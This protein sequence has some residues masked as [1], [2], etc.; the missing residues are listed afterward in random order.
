[1]FEK[2]KQKLKR[3][4][5]RV[6]QKVA[7]EAPPEVPP[8]V[9]PEAPPEAPPKAPPEVPLPG[10]PRKA[11]RR[12]VKRITRRELAPEDVEDI[13]WELQVGLLESDVAVPVAD[14]VI[15]RVKSG[16]KGRKLGMR[17]DPKK[18]AD[19]VLRQAIQEVLTT[20]QRVDLLKV[21]DAKRARGEPAVI[22]F[23][24][25]NG[26]GKCVDGNTLIP[27]VDGRMLEIKQIYEEMAKIY[28]EKEVENGF[29]IEEGIPNSLQIF[30]VNPESLKIEAA[31]PS[32]LWKLN[33]DQL[34]QVR[35]K[36]GASVRVT[37]EHPFFVLSP[38]ARIA[39][40]QAQRLRPGDFVMLPRCLPEPAGGQV[41]FTQFALRQMAKNNKLFVV[42]QSLVEDL[43]RFLK[44]KFG[45]LGTAWKSLRVNRSYLTFAHFW[46]KEGRIPARLLVDACKLGYEIPDGCQLLIKYGRSAPLNVHPTLDERLLEFL[47]F[48]YSEGHLEKCYV[49]ITNSN[50]QYLREYEQLARELFP[51]IKT[52]IKP[53]KRRKKLWDARTNSRALVEFLKLVFD[54]PQ[55]R[56]RGRL[57]LPDIITQQPTD[58]LRGFL[59]RY[60]EGEAYIGRDYHLVEVSTASFDFHRKLSSI[61]LRFGIVPRVGV[62]E[63]KGKK[64]YRVYISG[65]RSFERFVENF[66]LST[67]RTQLTSIAKFPHQFDDVELVPNVGGLVSAARGK[68]G[69]TQREISIGLRTSQ[70][71]ISTYES[72]G[73][74][75]PRER[76]ASF[77]NLTSEKGENLS[78]SRLAV[79]ANSD[80]CWAEVKEITTIRTSGPV[81]DLSVDGYQNFIANNVVV[82]NTTTIAKL[83][84]YLMDRGYKPVLAAADT[85]RA[86]GI[87]QLEI[88]AERLG[89]GVIK[90]R[91]GADAAAVAYDAIAHAKA[92]GLDV[93]LVDTAGRMQTD[94]NLMDE[95]RKIV[96]VAKPDLT[97]FVG[98]ALTGNDAVEQARTFDQAVGISGSILCKMD[99]DA[100]GGAALSITQVTGKPILFL[101]TGQGYDDLVEFKPEILL[102]AL[103][104]D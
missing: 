10:K 61:L 20:E 1:M 29:V 17:E 97:I 19:K 58:K 50:L 67:K 34:I 65:Y 76:L 99:A 64:Y 56:K 72:N 3:V 25:I 14:H 31:R 90:Q 71:L 16:L 6:S 59:R 27:L 47:G 30:A 68:A 43:Y 11:L 53:D 55:G 91:R 38:G 100:R 46:R 52:V 86:A 89:V 36:N 9:P 13:I 93:V 81:Y 92:R 48:I 42:S 57:T 7:P 103:F 88:H 5:E 49:E 45:S 77:I 18:L 2:L 62:K 28:V 96:R 73:A 8:E 22:V 104:G 60:F 70:S 82:H 39:K 26:H 98:D 54:F 74:R 21:I 4:M 23:V 79:L 78:W 94:V 83:A 12:V 51:T 95:M 35:L 24:G 69:L 84:R 80:V 85:F 75:I 37:P 33:T 40:V 41:D 32:A 87:E 15:E 63:I 66:P 101:G 102:N 44:E